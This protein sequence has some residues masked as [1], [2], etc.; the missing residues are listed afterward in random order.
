[1]NYNQTV[2][3]K[4]ACAPP[5][6]GALL[7][8]NFLSEFVT[9]VDKQRARFNL[10]IPDESS[11]NWGNIGGSIQNQ[12]DLINLIDEKLRDPK[13]KVNTCLSKIDNINNSIGNLSTKIL[14]IEGNYA[15]NEDFTSL[16][17]DLLNLQIAVAHNSTDIA[18]MIT[19]GDTSIAINVRQNTQDIADLKTKITG[20]DTQQVLDKL[21]DLESKINDDT[22]HTTEAQLQAQISILQGQITAIQQSI[23]G[24]VTTGITASRTS[25]NATPNSSN[26]P[27]TITASYSKL[28]DQ[29]VTDLCDVQIE[30]TNVA[31]WVNKQIVINSQL[32]ISKSTV[33]N[34]TYD[35]FTVS[36]PINVTVAPQIPTYKQYIGYADEPQ[37]LINTQGVNTVSGTWRENNSPDVHTG[38]IYG[39]WIITT[40][41]VNSIGESVG[42]YTLTDIQQESIIIEDTAYKVYMVG[43]TSESNLTINITINNGKY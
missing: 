30:D 27:I 17:K 16:K 10:G 43:P 19:G 32:E 35:G 28:K 8:T 7:K 15:K 9:E 36:I 22:L 12:A 14:T 5:P 40:E 4:P 20:L 6:Q 25:V 2:V 39:F 18:G 3:T 29:D 34:F 24:N 1:M 26:I 38:N 33:I 37:Q 21:A 41:D 23:G 31:Q 42:N 11:F 13:Q